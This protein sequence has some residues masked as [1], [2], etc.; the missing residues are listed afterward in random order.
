MLGRREFL[1]RMAAL[2][3]AGLSGCASME[4]PPEPPAL[5]ARDDD[6]PWDRRADQWRP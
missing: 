5:P 3:A 1:G 4:A 6:N 2:G